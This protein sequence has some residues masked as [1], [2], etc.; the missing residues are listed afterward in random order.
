M[1]WRRIP[2]ELEVSMATIID[3]CREEQPVPTARE[4]IAGRHGAEGNQSDYGI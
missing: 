3:A 2:A 1:I 4:P